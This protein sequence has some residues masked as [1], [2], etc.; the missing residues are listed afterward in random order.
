[1]IG[2]SQKL[3]LGVMKSLDNAQLNGL[4]SLNIS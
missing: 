1:M 2:T 4:E 3:L